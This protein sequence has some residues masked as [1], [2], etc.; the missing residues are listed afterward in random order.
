[1]TTS[2][3][4][5]CE[6][7]LRA[8]INYNIEH[9][10]WPSAIAVAERLLARRA[11]LNDAYAELVEKLGRHPHALKVFFDLLLCAA[12]LRHPQATARSRQDRTE[13]TQV[14]SQIAVLALELSSLLDRRSDIHNTTD[15][16]SDTH[17]SVC[18]VIEAAARNVPLFKGWIKEPLQALSGRFDLKYWPSLSDFVREISRDAAQATPH[19]MDQAAAAATTGKR[20]SPTDFFGY[21]YQDL[22]ESMVRYGGFIPNNFKVS[23]RSMA[24]L[25][26]CALGR[27]AD[28]PFDAAYVKQVRQRLRQRDLAVGDQ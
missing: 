15:F 1:M 18:G 9:S 2:P 25:A 14:N 28:E 22:E 19:A 21:L 8:D 10:I 27:E 7:I 23:D 11:E 4:Q 13:L 6:E 20:A 5:A 12:A 16:H 3:T 17:Y 26:T 24:S